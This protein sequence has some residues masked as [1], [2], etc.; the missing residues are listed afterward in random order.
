MEEE[1]EAASEAVEEADSEGTEEVA[2]EEEVEGVVG[3]S[4]EVN[5]GAV[6]T[7]N[8]NNLAMYFFCTSKHHILLHVINNALIWFCSDCGK[9]HSIKYF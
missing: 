4:E 9:K 3:D 7:G 1:E 2:S 5:V 6:S 8:F